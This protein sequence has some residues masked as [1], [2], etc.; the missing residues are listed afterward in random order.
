MKRL[1]LLSLAL[2]AAAAGVAR[3]DERDGHRTLVIDGRLRADRANLDMDSVFDAM[4]GAVRLGVSS[5]KLV[6]LK[7]RAD[8]RREEVA[9]AVGRS[10]LT[11]LF[12]VS[13]GGASALV[14]FKF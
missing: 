13:L 4:I 5:G 2:W 14:R 8:G 3:A 10:Q 9:L 6:P 1:L 7:R 12:D 11:P